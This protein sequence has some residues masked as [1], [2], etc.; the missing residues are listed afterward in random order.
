MLS[1]IFLRISPAVF[2]YNRMTI[3]MSGYELIYAVLK[4]V[5]EPGLS[6]KLRSNG[7]SPEF[8]LFIFD[9]KMASFD[10]FL[11]VFYAI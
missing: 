4:V 6:R 5:Q 9:L 1:K 7:P 10:T 8:Y 2:N 3:A 11:L